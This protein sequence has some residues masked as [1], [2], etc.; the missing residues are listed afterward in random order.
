MK[1][2]IA[3]CLLAAAGLWGWAW[4]WPKDAVPLDEAFV[5]LYHVYEFVPPEDVD[6]PNPQPRGQTWQYEFLPNGAYVFTVE[7]PDGLEMSRREGTVR[8]DDDL[9]TLVQ[10]SENRVASPLPPER[11]RV[12]WETVDAEKV[13]GRPYAP[14]ERLRVLVMKHADEGHEFHLAPIPTP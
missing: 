13:A 11:Y 7:L 5:G 4:F 1:P 12:R 9:L 6:M 8:V 2:F 10:A 14:G 3:V